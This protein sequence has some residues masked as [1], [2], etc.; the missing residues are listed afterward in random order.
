MVCKVF[1]LFFFFKRK[2]AEI[3][4]IKLS[5]PAHLIQHIAHGKCRAFTII[6]LIPVT[7]G[8]WKYRALEIRI[9]IV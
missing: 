2:T 1:V 7:A 5:P 9:N 6:R 8:I 4:V 3:K